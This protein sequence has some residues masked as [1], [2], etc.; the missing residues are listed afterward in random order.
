[1]AFIQGIKKDLKD[2]KYLK[3]IQRVFD[4][5]PIHC[6]LFVTDKCNLDCHYCNEYD[7]SKPHPTLQDLQR[8]IDKIVDL[9]V[10]KI[11]LVGGEPLLHPQICDV[12][13]YIKS[14]GLT[15][16]ISTNGW[17]LK[18]AMVDRLVEA[19]LDIVQVSV[20]RKTESA[21]TRK[22]IDKIDN[23]IAYLMKTPIKVHI[24]GVLCAATIDEAKDVLNYGLSRE[25]PTELRLL[26][27]D[28]SGQLLTAAA[29][30]EKNRE[31]IDLQ[32]KL[33]KEGKPVHTTKRILDYQ[34]ETLDGKQ[35][36]WTCL[37]GY[38]IFF[39]SAQ[40]DFWLCS[41]VR[42]EKKIEDVTAADLRSHNRKKKCQT[43]C[44][45]YCVISNSLFAQNPLD[46]VGREIPCKIKQ[47]LRNLHGPHRDPYIPVE[48]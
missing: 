28:A 6:N 38:K 13:R 29:S 45:I 1:M 26:H 37:A 22:C 23:Y 5:K 25:I 36:D 47:M 2:I 40:G 32:I 41:Q 17:L 9:G 3:A 39:V 4:D 42:T 44:G 15:A 11:A 27:G 14:K 20:D 24:A 34:R 33:K 31:F 35:T 46:Y 21:V 8:R 43:H 10:I 18:P 12:V 19:G 30:A 48:V 16:S 7:N